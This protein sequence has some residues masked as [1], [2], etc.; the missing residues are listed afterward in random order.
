MTTIMFDPHASTLCL[1]IIGSG[2]MGRGIAQIA[3]ASGIRVLL[4]DA[5]DG[6]ADEARAAVAATFDRLAAKGRMTAE[7]V[8]NAKA[9]LQAVAGY[10][11]AFRDCHVV[12]EAIVEDLEVKRS[13]FGQLEAIVAP[14]C[15]LATNTSSLSVT[16]IAAACRR[17]ERV[18]GFHFFNPVP[19]MRIVEVVP[20]VLTD[21][22]VT[23]S[24]EALGTR[25]GHGVAVARD[26]PGFL[27]NHAGRGYGTE[28]LRIVGEGIASTADVD[29]I[30]TGAAGFRMGP[31]ELMDLI[32]IDVSR[33]VMESLYD[34]FYQEPRFRP[35]TLPR[36]LVS[37]NLLGRK[38]GRGFYAYEG[39]KPVLPPDPSPP[40][41]RPLPIWIGRR[42]PEGAALLAEAL[43]GAGLDIGER[44]SAGSACIVVPLGED[45]TTAALAEALDPARTVAVDTL[46]G[47]SGRHTLM[48]NP[49]TDPTVRDAVH[50]TLGQGGVPVTVIHDSPG[51]VAQRVVA[52]IVN[53]GCDIAQQRIASPEAIDRAVTLGLG[54][55]Q[56]PLALGD[57]L[58]A[59]RILAVLEALR[60]ATGDPRYRASPWLRRRAL[61]NVSLTTPET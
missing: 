20:G 15:V 32:G 28:A 12:V 50:R 2:T 17:P 29:R 10:A 59:R 49:V 44:P 21:P 35:T 19:L 7:A 3:A 58:G 54:Y 18:A 16:A 53:I 4:A 41:T 61:L 57:R 46:F 8:G 31:F 33:A 6:A 34:Q 5:R 30:L 38:T 60:A 9:C 47:L 24:L 14:D 26:T 37:A 43:A 45:C 51:F 11:P 39:G 25:M 27:V 1:G 22:R 52:T 36:Q 55:P 48:T 23:A 42:N 56:G 40:D 13:L